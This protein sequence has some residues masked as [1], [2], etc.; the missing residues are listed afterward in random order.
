MPQN[1]VIQFALDGEFSLRAIKSKKKL[2]SPLFQSF[3]DRSRIMLSDRLCKACM[4]SVSG[5]AGILSPLG[6]YVFFLFH[7]LAC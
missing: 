2:Y 7:C 4:M 3:P 6:L 1:K 5:G